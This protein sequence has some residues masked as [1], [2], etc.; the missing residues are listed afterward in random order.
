MKKVNNNYYSVSGEGIVTATTTE[1]MKA[2]ILD[3]VERM[4]NFVKSMGDE[5]PM[6]RFSQIL[7]EMMEIA[8]DIDEKGQMDD[9]QMYDVWEL[10]MMFGDE[11]AN[12]MPIGY[13]REYLEMRLSTII[14][15]LQGEKVIVRG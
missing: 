6:L 13:A 14:K 15:V 10:I 11:V 1:G 9:E 3:K 7:D 5:L 4:Y 12:N 8:K 2:D